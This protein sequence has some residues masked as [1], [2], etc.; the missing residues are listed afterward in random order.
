MRYYSP[1]T[2]NLK[3]LLAISISHKVSTISKSIR[4]KKGWNNTVLAAAKGK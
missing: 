3:L 2:G 1:Q 4:L